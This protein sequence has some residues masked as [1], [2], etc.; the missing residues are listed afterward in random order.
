[1]IVDAFLEVELHDS[2]LHRSK[3]TYAHEQGTDAK[4]SD[5]LVDVHVNVSTLTQDRMML[6]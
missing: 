5:D 1:M 6:P 2:R 3:E 4:R